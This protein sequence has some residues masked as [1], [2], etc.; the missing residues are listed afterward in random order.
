M[1][2]VQNGLP[3]VSD[4]CGRLVEKYV[5]NKELGRSGCE[6]EPKSCSVEAL[7]SKREEDQS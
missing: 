3:V 7:P 1:G 4:P 5:G 6:T 2:L